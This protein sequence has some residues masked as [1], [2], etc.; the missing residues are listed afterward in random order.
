[1]IKLLSFDQF[2]KYEHSSVIFLIFNT[3]DFVLFELLPRKTVHYKNNTDFARTIKF[4]FIWRKCTPHERSGQ[5][6]DFSFR[7]QSTNRVRAPYSQLF[8]L[9]FEA[10]LCEYGSYSLHFRMFWYIHKLHL[11]ASFA[12]YSLINTVVLR[13]RIRDQ[14]PFGPLVI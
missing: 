8:F 13:I 2:I 12:S 5:G 10:N 14:V 7:R 6:E 11:F 3:V 9:R 4:A 1:M